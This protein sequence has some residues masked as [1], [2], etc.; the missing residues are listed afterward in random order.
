MH[1]FRYFRM[2]IFDSGKSSRFHEVLDDDDEITQNDPDGESHAPAKKVTSPEEPSKGM[3]QNGSEQGSQAQTAP[4]DKDNH[5]TS[6]RHGVVKKVVVYSK[7]AVGRMR[8]VISR[9]G[10]PGRVP[11]KEGDTASV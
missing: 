7:A 6:R 11:R 4:A 8:S 9:V 10:R 2:L 1:G 5:S 3:D